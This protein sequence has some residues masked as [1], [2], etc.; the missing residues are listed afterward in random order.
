ML[1]KFS[2]DKETFA[3]F[4]KKLG[5]VCSIW[6]DMKVLYQY[7]GNG[8]TGYYTLWW[9][10]VEVFSLICTC[11]ISFSGMWRKCWHAVFVEIYK[12]PITSRGM[13]SDLV[14]TAIFFL[15]LF[16]S[17]SCHLK[18]P[19]PWST[20]VVINNPMQSLSY[21][22]HSLLFG[23]RQL[24][25]WCFSWFETIRHAFQTHSAC[26]SSTDGCL[27]VGS[28]SGWSF[29]ESLQEHDLSLWPN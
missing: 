1:S 7:R 22:K 15:G 2:W 26:K 12:T 4:F 14:P 11:W 10:R 19:C 3:Y 20:C 23:K 25:I 16:S 27:A 28:M 29:S 18:P 24:F 5:H 9:S 6:T 21:L 8:C 13:I 17:W